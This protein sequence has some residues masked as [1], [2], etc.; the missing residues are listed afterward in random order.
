MYHSSGPEFSILG[1]FYPLNPLNGNS[2]VLDGGHRQ[3]H[4]EVNLRLATSPRLI[5]FGPSGGIGLGLDVQ[6]VFNSRRPENFNSGFS[7]TRFQ[8]GRRV[9][10]TLTGSF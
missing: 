4:T 6:N 8:L 9:L 2:N 5:G 7:G 3:A 10:L 1:Q